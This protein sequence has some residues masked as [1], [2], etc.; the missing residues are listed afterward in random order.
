MPTYN[1][2]MTLF[3]G[4]NEDK[5]KARHDVGTHTYRA[6][7]LTAIPT[8]TTATNATLTEVTGDNYTAG[9]VDISATLGVSG[10]QATIQSSVDLAQ[11]WIE[12]AGGFTDAR[13]IAIRN[14][15]TG[16]LVC[17]GDITQDGGTTPVSSVDGP[18]DVN[19]N[20]GTNILREG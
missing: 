2:T 18:V 4:Y 12:S 15:T 6:M 10:A 16:R 17:F 1:A 3:N 9:G 11:S 5:L 8:A 14:A 13:A 20:G 19:W 7:L